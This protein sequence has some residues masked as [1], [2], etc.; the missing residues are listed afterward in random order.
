MA[1][2]MWWAESRRF[3]LVDRLAVRVALVWG[4]A[5]LVDDL[6][7]LDDG[8]LAGLARAEEEDLALLLELA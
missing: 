7:L 2:M 6:H 3:V 5:V 8:A 1:R 4:V